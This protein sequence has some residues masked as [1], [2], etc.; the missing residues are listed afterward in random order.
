ML[1]VLVL[2]A[3][4][5]SVG[6]LGFGY[7]YAEVLRDGALKPDREP[8]ELDLEVTALDEGRVTL[9]PTDKA[10]EDGDWTHRGTFGLEWAGG[11]AQVGEILDRDDEQVVRE[12]FPWR[13]SLRVGDMVRLDSFAFPGDPQQAHGIPFEE[14]T[15]PARLGNFPAWFVDGPHDTWAIFVHGKGANRRES[16]RMLPVFHQLGL[17]SL[18]ITYR[19]DEEAPTNADGYYR[20]GETEWEEL[21][22]AAQYAV[23][24]GA[25]RVILVG[26][27]MGGAIV[28]SF[29]LQSSLSQLVEGVILDAPMLDLE[30]IVDKESRD[31]GVPGFLTNVGK[32]IAGWRFNI[33]WGEVDYLS[34]ADELSVPILLFHGEADGTVFVETSDALAEIRPDIVT[35]VRS[36]GVDHVR[37]WNAAPAA[38]EAAVRE[39]A[40]RLIE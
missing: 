13:G 19:N 14:V 9:R 36:V 24:R 39:F 26:Y 4:V 25:E 35:Y 2:I 17:P 22:A 20:Q 15:F 32:A 6:L 38:Y 18:V 12:F 23:D 11:Y 10:D 28:M 33:H 31:R 37:S 30:A 27:S 3:L 16:L 21:Q 40:V 29:L 7:Y 1:F 5:A 8:D 34:R